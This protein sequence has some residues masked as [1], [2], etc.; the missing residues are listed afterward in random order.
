MFDFLAGMMKYLTVSIVTIYAFISYML[1]ICKKQVVTKADRER[2]SKVELLKL[3]DK[4]NREYKFK[5]K[6]MFLSQ[7]GLIMV[8]HILN[9]IVLIA[10]FDEPKYVVLGS[11]ELI[12]MVAITKIYRVVYS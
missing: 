6:L 2:L 4:Y 8:L 5:K 12:F 9:Y 3:K 11:L 10:R 1:F 7:Y